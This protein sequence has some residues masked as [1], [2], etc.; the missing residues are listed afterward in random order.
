MTFTRLRRHILGIALLCCAATS[1]HA[2]A[3]RLVVIDQDASGPGGS[4]QLSMV[5]LLQSP[6]V[7]VLGI[8]TVTGNA[9]MAEETAHTLRMLELLGRRDVPVYRGAVQ[10]LVRTYPETLLQ[11]RLY[12]RYAW[13]GAWGGRVTEGGTPMHAPEFVPPLPEGEPRLKPAAEDAAH[14]LVRTVREHPHEVTI[15]AAG[16]MTNLALAQRIDPEFASLAKELVFM[17]GALNPVTPDDEFA[18]TPHHE[19]NLW[20]DPEAAHIVLTAP[21]ARV[22]ATT[23]DVS[24]KTFLKPVLVDAIADSDSPAAR[25]LQQWSQE[26]FYMWDELAALAWLHPALI[27]REREVYLDVNLDRGASYGDML[28]WTD[29]MKPEIPHPLVH[30]QMDVDLPAFERDFVALMRAPTPR[31]R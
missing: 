7:Q 22:T 10:P 20:F 21:W 19:F 24:I 9:W 16:P 1:A 25:Y 13:L 15:W 28:A 18:T 2:A 27:T 11:T 30:A 6:D 14:F 26:R 31:T 4:N 3:P 29:K 8:S 17:G 12:G 5:L 23:V